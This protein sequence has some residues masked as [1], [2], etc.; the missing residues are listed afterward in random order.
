VA[1]T[2]D[3][4]T[5]E[6]EAGWAAEVAVRER[7]SATHHSVRLRRQTFDELATGESTP[8]DLIAASFRFLLEREAKESI[9][10]EFDLELIARF[11]PEY[12]REIHRY[13]R[14]RA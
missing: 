4:E 10:R 11:F 2:I 6:T 14:P 12:P 1:A 7:D 5:A 9:L 13:L 3:V 8:H